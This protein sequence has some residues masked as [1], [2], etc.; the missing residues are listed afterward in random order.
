MQYQQNLDK[1]SIQLV[2]LLTYDNR[3]KTLVSKVPLIELELRKL[4]EST[5]VIIVDLR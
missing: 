4:P 2:V 5:K 3:Y 1:H